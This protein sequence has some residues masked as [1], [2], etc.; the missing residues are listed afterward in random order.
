MIVGGREK[1]VVGILLDGSSYTLVLNLVLRE[2]G[3]ISG[4]RK[5][6]V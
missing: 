5:N 4:G 6:E 1:S 3:Y 2:V